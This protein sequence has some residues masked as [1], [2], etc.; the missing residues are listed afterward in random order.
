MIKLWERCEV[1][2]IALKRDAHNTDS[3]LI[4]EEVKVGAKPFSRC[5]VSQN[6][7]F[8]CPCNVL[9]KEA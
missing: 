5:S 2:K 4:T 7:F 6:T 3:E 9:V 8:V 1:A